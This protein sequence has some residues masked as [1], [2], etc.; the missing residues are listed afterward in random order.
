MARMVNDPASQL[1][2]DPDEQ[3][4]APR[5][6]RRGL[7]LVLAGLAVLAAAGWWWW[8]QQGPVPPAPDPIAQGP[9]ASPPQEQAV[10]GADPRYPLEP[11]AA[12]P[13]LAGG[14]LAGALSEL[15]GQAAVTTFLHTG[16]FPRRV[17]ATVDNLGRAHAPPALWPVLPTPGR[18][19]VRQAPEGE[20]IA[21]ENAQRYAP[22]VRMA[23]GVDAARAAEVYRQV[24]P[25]L[26][27][28]YRELG[29]GERYFN[30]RVVEVIDLLL[31]TPE[32]GTPPRVQLTEV[33]GPI[34][35][36]RPWVRYEFADP[37]L[38]SLSAGQKILVRM[39]PGNARVLKQKL[40]EFRAQVASG[41]AGPR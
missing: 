10:P 22:F 15:L 18:F 21:A 9:A 3:H 40:A 26:Q 24:Y 27:Q 19:S 32:P 25:L 30:D 31:A 38:A 17:V 23:A 41:S 8:G 33:K 4:R 37:R 35:S 39:G 12:A 7:G 34:A 28:T 36:E 20:A 2:A 16:D 14:D 1:R 5:R 6:K 29:F 13:A 11:A